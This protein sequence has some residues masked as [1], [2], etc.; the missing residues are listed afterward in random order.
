MKTKQILIVSDPN[1]N[2]EGLMLWKNLSKNFDTILVNTDERA[3]E[4]ANRQHFDMVVIDNSNAAIDF[5]KLT[6]V[7]PIFQTDIALINFTDESIME[8]E[9]KV[10][11]LF[12]NKR[13]ERIKRFLVLDSSATNAWD[14]LPPFSV[15]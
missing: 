1:I 10:K 13:N 6:A 12:I 2:E 7:L 9:N 4:L 14:R 8:M 15:N 5:K 11:A 3:I